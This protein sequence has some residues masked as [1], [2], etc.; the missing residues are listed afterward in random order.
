MIDKKCKLC[1]HLASAHKMGPSERADAREMYQTIIRCK[2]VLED[3]SD[4]DCF[5]K[6]HTEYKVI[7][8]NGLLIH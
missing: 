6:W 2:A 1:H 4:C 7:G 5:I 3:G 8:H